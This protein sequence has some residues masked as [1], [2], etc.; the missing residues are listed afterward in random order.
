MRGH[1]TRARL[2]PKNAGLSTTSCAQ[3]RFFTCANPRLQSAQ[4]V[5]VMSKFA[6]LR[7]I[8]GKHRTSSFWC[9]LMFDLG[10]TT[11]N[12]CTFKYCDTNSGRSKRSDVSGTAG[13]LEIMNSVALGTAGIPTTI[14]SVV[15]SV[16]MV[17]C[18]R[19]CWWKGSSSGRPSPGVQSPSLGH[20]F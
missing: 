12:T 10:S 3:R 17:L 20:H 5:A 18:G 2:Y 9:C 6:G 8:F 13:I 7:W 4:T 15:F 11:L 16:R 14:I 1:Q 19:L